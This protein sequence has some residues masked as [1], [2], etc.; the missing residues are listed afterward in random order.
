MG[1]L[2][3]PQCRHCRQHIRKGPKD[4]ATGQLAYV[5]YTVKLPRRSFDEFS[6]WVY[7]YMYFA[8]VLAPQELVEKHK[9]AALNLQQLYE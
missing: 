3:Q 1:L 8:K 2:S 7:R 6:R 4:N 9:A 5:D